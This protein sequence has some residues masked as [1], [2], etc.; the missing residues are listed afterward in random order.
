MR[1]S[2]SRSPTA[3]PRPTRGTCQRTGSVADVGQSP[4][5]AAHQELCGHGV[6]DLRAEVVDV[7]VGD[8]EVELSLVVRVQERDAESEAL[9]GRDRQAELNV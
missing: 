4:S 9:A 7:A 1:P 5:L 8:G 3:K 6:G 2:L